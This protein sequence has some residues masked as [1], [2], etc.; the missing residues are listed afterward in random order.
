MC[1][2]CTN[3]LYA[4]SSELTYSQEAETLFQRALAR[5]IQSKYDEAKLSLQELLT[6]HPSNQ[7]TSAAQLMLAKTHFKLKDYS[8][9]IA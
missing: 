2:L 6:Q 1:L 9:A 7:R 4:Q 5:Y 3:T 8:L